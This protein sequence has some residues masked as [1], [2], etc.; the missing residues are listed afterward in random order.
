MDE[1]GI[2]HGI[3]EGGDEMTIIVRD[4]LPP[5]HPLK[6]VTIQFR[7]R[8]EAAAAEPDPKAAFRAGLVA[9]I[10]ENHPAAS[11]AEINE[12]LDDMGC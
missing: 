1:G 3:T 5:G 10:K 6:G 8:L 11:D 7:R 4:E 2:D 9:D 12:M